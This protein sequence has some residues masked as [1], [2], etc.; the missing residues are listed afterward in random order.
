MID[1]LFLVPISLVLGLVGL[2]AFLWCLRSRQYD[3]LDGDAERI[4]FTQ[5]DAPIVEDA[6]AEAREQPGEEAERDGGAD[7]P[8][9][10]TPPDQRE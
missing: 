9:A 8:A 10:K 5:D 7:Q 1:F 3:D 2:V 4:L 6:S